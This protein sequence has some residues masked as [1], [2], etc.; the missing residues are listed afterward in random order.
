MN[1]YECRSNSGSLVKSAFLMLLMV[2]PLLWVFGTGSRFGG[3]TG[4]RFSFNEAQPTRLMAQRLVQLGIDA[5][6]D[7][8]FVNDVL[9][10]IKA[11]AAEGDVAA[12]AF[13]VEYFAESLRKQ[14]A[15]SAP[16]SSENAES[17]DS[18]SL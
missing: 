1:E 12:A 6:I 11:R 18:A 9:A 7:E 8:A 14:A 17:P 15:E 4:D 16:V 2:S 3:G 13:V 5:D 10:N